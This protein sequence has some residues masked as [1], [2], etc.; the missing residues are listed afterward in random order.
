MER[1]ADEERTLAADDVDEEE[2]AYD[3]GNQLDDTK[4]G[5]DQEGRLGTL[6][7]EQVEEI[8]GVQRDGTRTRPFTVLALTRDN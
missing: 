5:R 1:D 8:R 2:G 4:H 6:D 3:G 7:A